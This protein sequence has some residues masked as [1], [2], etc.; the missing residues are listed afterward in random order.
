MT[1]VFLLVNIH[2]WQATTAKAKPKQVRI[3][4]FKN[5]YKNL[6]GKKVQK[7]ESKKRGIVTNVRDGSHFLK[8]M[9]VVEMGTYKGLYSVRDIE[10]MLKDGTH[11]HNC[12]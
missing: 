9:I 11:F 6:I 12:E 5:E 8:D 2:T 1:G 7:V 3:E 4:M 10:S